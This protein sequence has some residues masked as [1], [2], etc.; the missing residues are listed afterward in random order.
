V[1]PGLTF[2]IDAYYKNKT[3]L[4]D[5]GQFGSS[6][7]LSP[8][9]YADGYAWGLELRAN[10]VHGPLSLY[11]NLARGQEKGRNI[12]SSQFFFAPDELAYIATHYI[13]TDHSQKWTA[14]GGVS[15]TINDGLGTI[16]PTTDFLYGDGLRAAD[17]NGIV[18]NGGKL[19][20]Y[21]TANLGI[22]QNFDGP[23]FLKGL[24]IRFDVT[25]ITDKIYLIRDGSGV[26]VGAP[27]YGQR[28]GFFAGI[29]KSF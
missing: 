6:L 23:G 18:P 10:Y 2:G 16:V 4:L 26:G 17:P 19:P 24:S 5:E 1:A 29:R 27:Q 13:Y 11:A 9:N 15:M 21:F 14:S 22:A 12:V 20:S 25:N 3:N 8:F 7:V 28:R